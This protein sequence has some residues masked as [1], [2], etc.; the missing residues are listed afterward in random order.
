MQITGAYETIVV[1]AKA[2]ETEHP[3]ARATPP[4]VP[5][6]PEDRPLPP[7]VASP[8]QP[9]VT[10]GVESKPPRQRVQDAIEDAQ[11]YMG[12][13]EL[14][15]AV[16]VLYEVVQVADDEQRG[17]IRLLLATAYVADPKRRRNALTLLSDIVR[18]QPS[19]AEALRLLGTLYS[20]DGLLARAE[21][22]LA[23]A[24]EADPGHLQAR[25]NL[26]AVRATLQ[27]R[28]A[29]KER[30]TDGGGLFARLLA[31]AR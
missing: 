21:S 24:V 6:S 3:V 13:K 30:K 4:V 7:G 12:R 28:S 27:Q 10:A 1:D 5:P 26:R 17:K 18:E 11:A 22:T 20:R 23:R 14:D 9:H 31:M 15:A 29:S 19:N 25:A 8:E 16:D 2:A